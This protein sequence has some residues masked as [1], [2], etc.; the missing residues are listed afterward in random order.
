MS[1][2][3]KSIQQIAEPG[4]SIGKILIEFY[5]TMRRL[6]SDDHSGGKQATKIIMTTNDI[7]EVFANIKPKP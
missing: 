1:D 5:E 3:R 4:K 2:I 6:E 7:E